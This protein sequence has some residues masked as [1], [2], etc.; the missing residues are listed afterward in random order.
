MARVTADNVLAQKSDLTLKNEVKTQRA[1]VVEEVETIDRL[2]GSMTKYCK[3]NLAN[4]AATTM[5]KCKFCDNNPL[6][7][8]SK[9]RRFASSGRD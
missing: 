3:E 2:S 4:A 8:Y 1:Q 7:K 5:I 6:L 9:E